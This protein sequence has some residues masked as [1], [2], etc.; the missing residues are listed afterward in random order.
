MTDSCEWTELGALLGFGCTL[1]VLIFRCSFLCN[2][3]N[4]R[5]AL[6]SF[7]FFLNFCPDRAGFEILTPFAP[8]PQKKE[9]FLA[10]QRQRCHI[11]GCWINFAPV[12]SGRTGFGPHV[13]D[14]LCSTHFIVLLCGLLALLLSASG[15]P[16]IVFLSH[17][18]YFPLTA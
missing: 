10:D 7:S 8:P 9:C 13:P 18:L 17:V 3:W 4:I 12:V 2:I 14:Y 16:E 1:K 11:C 6:E 15:L 5:N